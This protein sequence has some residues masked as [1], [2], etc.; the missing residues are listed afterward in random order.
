VQVNMGG[1]VSVG[2]AGRNAA[3]ERRDKPR[4]Y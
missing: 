4:S 1:L 2:Y 3:S